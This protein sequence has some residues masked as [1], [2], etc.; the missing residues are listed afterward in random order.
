MEKFSG[1]NQAQLVA[2]LEERAQELQFVVAFA[3]R[4]PRVAPHFAPDAEELA[5][6]RAFLAYLQQERRRTQPVSRRVQ[7]IACVQASSVART[8]KRSAAVMR[9]RQIVV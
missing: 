1:I 2:E 8:S 4:T 7:P 5:D 9:L 3:Q 6:V